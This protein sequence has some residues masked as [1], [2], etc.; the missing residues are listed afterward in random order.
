[1]SRFGI[2][3]RYFKISRYRFGFRFF[4]GIYSSLLSREFTQIDIKNFVPVTVVTNMS[5]I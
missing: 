2:R 1:V 3:H 5:T 4:R